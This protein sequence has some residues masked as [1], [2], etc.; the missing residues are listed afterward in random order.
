[1]WKWFNERWQEVESTECDVDGRE[2]TWTKNEKRKQGWEAPDGT[3][4]FNKK[5]NLEEKI[6][7]LAAFALP[8]ARAATPP[9]RGEEGAS[10]RY[11]LVVMP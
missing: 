2:K 4:Y 11:P 1:M 9:V 7:N 3:T 6:S 10:G 5:D 8:S